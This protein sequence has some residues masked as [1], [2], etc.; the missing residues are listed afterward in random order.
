MVAAVA[1]AVFHALD[2]LGSPGAGTAAE[3]GEP[4]S[5]WKRAGRQEAMRGP[6]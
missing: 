5:Q 2:E 1:A 3:E 6:A 4:V